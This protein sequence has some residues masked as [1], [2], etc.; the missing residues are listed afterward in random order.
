MGIYNNILHEDIELN[1]YLTESNL[2]KDDLKDKNKV[3]NAIEKEKKPENKILLCIKFIGMII[4]AVPITV[5]AIIIAAICYILTSNIEKLDDNKKIKIIDKV[6]KKYNKNIESLKKKLEK[7]T[8]KDEIKSIKSTI[9]KLEDDIKKLEKMKESINN[10]N[11]EYGYY[12]D[13]INK[14]LNNPMD[15][16]DGIAYYALYLKYTDISESEFINRFCKNSNETI[17]DMD[18]F[19]YANPITK[20]DTVDGFY[21]Y[22]LKNKGAKVVSFNLNGDA[23]IFWNCD[24]KEFV[25]SHDDWTVFKVFKFNEFKKSFGT[26]WYPKEYDK[27]VEADKLLGYYRLSKAPSG[28]KPKELPK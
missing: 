18:G 25:V 10:A 19:I 6:I 11:T 14:V 15:Y 1:Y 26:Y 9:K 5:G 17:E 7:E 23:G 21:E 3:I 12:C 22:Y 4:L 24:R 28:V 16:Y 8:N 13:N 2:N 27:Y 20:E